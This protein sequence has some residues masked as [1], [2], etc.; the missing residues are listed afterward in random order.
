LDNVDV[1]PTL[2]YTYDIPE[3]TVSATAS[4]FWNSTS[5]SEGM[6]MDNLSFIGTAIP[7]P[8]TMSLLAIGGIA[9]IRRRRR[10]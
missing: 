5:T 3:G 10:A 8:A 9:L 7:E 6:D 1:G 2:T 4:V